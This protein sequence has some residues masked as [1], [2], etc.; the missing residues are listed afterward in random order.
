VVVR[1]SSVDVVTSAPTTSTVGEL[2][3]SGHQQKTLR[4]EIRDNLLAALREGRDP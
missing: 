4:H 2:K 1:V 3:A